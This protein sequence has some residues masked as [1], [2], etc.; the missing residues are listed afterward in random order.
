MD[1]S[2]EAQ[3]A[4]IDRLRLAM[5]RLTAQVAREEFSV[6]EAGDVKLGVSDGVLQ[7]DRMT[8]ER[9]E[10][11]ALTVAQSAAMEYYERIV[12]QMFVR[13]GELVLRLER[14]GTVSLRTGPL[15]RFIG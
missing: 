11:V 14:K 15:H 4:E 8:P 12:D 7:V 5:P 2:K 3:T 1:V 13:T 10:I 9:S 6:R